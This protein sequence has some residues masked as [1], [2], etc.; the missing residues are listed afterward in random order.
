MSEN[1]DAIII[2]AGVIGGAVGFELAKKGWRTLNVDALPAAGYG[3]TSASCAIIRVHYST[4][5][6][7]ALA[8]EG[9]HYWEKWA[10]YLETTDEM[11]LAKFIQCGCLVYKADANNKMETILERARD[12]NVPVEEW[13][14]DQIRERLPFVDPSRFTPAKTHD[15]PEFGKPVGGEIYGAAFFPTAG[16]VNDPQLS[17]HNLQRAAEAKGAT[18]RFNSKVVEILQEGGRV[19]GVK[20]E[21]GSVISAK[22]VVN[23]AGPHSS[24]INDMAGVTDGFN[25]K[26]AALKQ[27]V[28]HVPAPEGF[29]Y[30]NQGFVVSDSDISVY[31]RPETGNNVLVGS[32]DPECDPRIFVD[33]D[34]WDE[35]F[36]DQWK[37]QVYRQAQRYQGLPVTAPVKGV[38][39]LYD[40]SDDWIPI[41]DCTDLPGFYAAV[42][43]SGNQYKNAP[44]A[45]KIMAHLIETC[46][47][48]HDHD[49]DPVQFH[50][51][52]IDR[53]INLGFYSRR[54]V[55]NTESSMSVLG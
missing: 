38:V 4:Y 32:E 16:Y 15:D 48:G 34:D 35:N 26:T 13:G 49:A 30:E 6:G 9:F 28:S 51:E 23:V 17:A 11:G 55:I 2:G 52:H 53:T 24:K 39:A 46:E 42:G 44:T 31:S 33:P 3:S 8:Y 36:T 40:A 14:I 54:R 43:T 45:G 5:D 7:C 19:S 50:L 21:D 22:V 47:N 1:Y 18:F 27:E 37:V 41:Y 10:D 20:L 25:I 12:L 29:D